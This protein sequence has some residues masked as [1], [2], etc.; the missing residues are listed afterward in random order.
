MTTEVLLK[1]RK[2]GAGNPA[3]EWTRTFYALHLRGEGRV[4]YLGKADYQTIGDRVRCESKGGVWD[5]FT[6]IGLAPRDVGLVAAE[7]F[8]DARWTS[9]L[10]ADVESLLIA[11]IRPV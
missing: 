9:E 4:L 6:Q 5:H 8:T 3:L 10:Q 2:I 1:W 7:V 11:R